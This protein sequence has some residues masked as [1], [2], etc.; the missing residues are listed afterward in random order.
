MA[1]CKRPVSLNSLPHSEHFSMS[2]LRSEVIWSGEVGGVVSSSL[3]ATFRIDKSRSMAVSAFRSFLN[4]LSGPASLLRFS[5]ARSTYPRA[6]APFFFTC[7]ACQLLQSLVPLDQKRHVPFSL[8][9]PKLTRPRS[10][11]IRRFLL[12]FPLIEPKQQE[13][14][15]VA[16]TKATVPVLFK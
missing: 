5:T 2:T 8:E 9:V 11:R 7:R 1:T 4:V 10:L 16:R 14:V 13:A 12:L 3:D 6:S 15:P